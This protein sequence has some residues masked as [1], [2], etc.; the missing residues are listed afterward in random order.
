MYVIPIW[1]FQISSHHK[2]DIMV[3]PVYGVGAAPYIQFWNHEGYSNKS[4]EKSEQL[5]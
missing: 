5:M 2:T 4:E 1:Y 3:V